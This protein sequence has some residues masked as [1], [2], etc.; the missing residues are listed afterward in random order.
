MIITHRKPDEEV[1]RS[2]AGVRSLF[3]VG[4]VPCA[5]SCQTGGAKEVVAWTEQLRADGV[6]VTGSVVVDSPCDERL[7]KRDFAAH[8]DE[9]A[10]AEALLVLT[11][12]VGVQVSADVAQKRAIPALNTSA[13]A[14]IQ[15]IGINQEYCRQCGDC[16]LADTAGICP[17]TRCAKGLRNGPCGGAHDGHCEVEPDRDC[18]W[19]LILKRLTPEEKERLLG[20]R[21]PRDYRTQGRKP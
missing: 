1:A 3:I 12:G 15:R 16:V 21:A 13:L 4:C 14:K 8:R 11:C 17:V 9:I 7:V 6:T 2:L 5:S 10:A 19:Q 18:A 20:L